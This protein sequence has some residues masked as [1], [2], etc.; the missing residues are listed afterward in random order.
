MTATE[1]VT[2]GVVMERRAARSAWVDHLWLPVAVL[3]GAPGLAHWTRLGQSETGERFFVG[4]F[5]LALHRTDTANYRDNLETGA[6]R[7]WVAARLSG[8]GGQPEV[9]AVTADPAEGE[10]FTEAGDDIVEHVAM[11]PEIAGVLAAFVAAHHVER[12]FIKRR[13]RRWD[14]EEPDEMA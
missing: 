9:I 2:V 8:P 12:A 5:D 1:T 14:A 4:A 11:A 7:I 10:A 13:R 6:P 3:P